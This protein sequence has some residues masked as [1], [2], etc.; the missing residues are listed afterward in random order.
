MAAKIMNASELVFPDYSG[1]NLFNSLGNILVNPNIG[2]IF[3]DFENAMRLRVNCRAE[4]IENP[5]LFSNVWSTSCR[6]I[7]VTVEQIYWNCAK[8]IPKLNPK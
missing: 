7:Q 6:Y 4:V 3:I 2:M 1:N 5:A 8:R